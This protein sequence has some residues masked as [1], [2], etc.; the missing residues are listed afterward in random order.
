MPPDNVQAS[1][2]T[3]YVSPELLKEIAKQLPQDRAFSKI[4]GEITR[5]YNESKRNPDGPVTTLHDLR[6]DP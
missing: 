4:Y 2:T 6:R 1:T 3:L 5:R